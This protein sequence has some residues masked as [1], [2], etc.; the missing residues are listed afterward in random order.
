MERF[1]KADENLES[2]GKQGYPTSALRTYIKKFNLSLKIKILK[3]AKD[4]LDQ[5]NSSN[6]LGKWDSG[7][8]F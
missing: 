6:H 3:R 7:L 5:V 4:V 1:S 2:E 8:Y